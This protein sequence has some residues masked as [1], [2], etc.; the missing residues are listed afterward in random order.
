MVESMQTTS[1]TTGAGST[2][3]SVMLLDDND[4]FYNES[5]WLN[6]LNIDGFSGVVPA[7][8]SDF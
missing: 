1:A 6:G 7:D 3:V 2:K 5:L 8:R 4:G